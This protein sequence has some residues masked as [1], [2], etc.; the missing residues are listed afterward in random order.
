M[1]HKMLCSPYK[2]YYLVLKRQKCS[3]IILSSFT[4]RV[5]KHVCPSKPFLFKVFEFE[6]RVVTFE[7]DLEFFI[8]PI[9]N[10][11]IYRY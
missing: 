7:I 1:L 5:R 4:T 9:T 8:N 10:I 3:S 11:N 2:Y 6:V